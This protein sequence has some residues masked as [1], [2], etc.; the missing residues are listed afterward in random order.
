[1]T[2]TAF[3][4]TT[5]SPESTC[6]TCS[7]FQ[8]YQDRGRGLCQVFE[9]VVRQH[10]TQTSDCQ[11]QLES[12]QLQELLSTNNAYLKPVINAFPGRDVYNWSLD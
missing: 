7:Q 9:R 2:Y 5:P 11:Q 8:D 4:T 10:H 6:A 1:M 12:E 3:N